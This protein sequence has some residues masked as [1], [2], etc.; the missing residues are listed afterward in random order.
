MSRWPPLVWLMVFVGSLLILVGYDGPEYNPQALIPGVLLI[1]GA[2]VL[3]FYF[4][5]AR[6][7]DRPSARGVS[8]L[9][10]ATMVFYAICAFVALLSGGEYAVAALGA[11]MIP[12]TAATLITATARAKTANAEGGRRETAAAEHTDP[13]PGIGI[14]DSTPLGDTPE[15]SDAERVATPDRRSWRRH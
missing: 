14:D 6:M 13:F 7:S 4:A 3:S 11:G 15:H 8:W 9:I 12:L 5:F 2:V 10:P 1:V